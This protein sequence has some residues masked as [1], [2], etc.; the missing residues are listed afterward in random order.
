[1]SLWKVFRYEMA[2][3]PRYVRISTQNTAAAASEDAVRA[4]DPNLR[5]LVLSHRGAAAEARQT[6]GASVSLAG[7]APGTGNRERGDQGTETTPVVT[8]QDLDPETLT[9]DQGTLQVDE[10]AAMQDPLGDEVFDPPEFSASAAGE[11][12]GADGCA[13][14]RPGSCQGVEASAVVAR[15]GSERL[16]EVLAECR[17]AAESA[18]GGDPVDGSVGRFEQSSGFVE[19]A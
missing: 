12:R 15:G 1:I 17:R 10:D 3:M 2:V 19:A 14:R 9:R 6:G 18:V 11:A 8:I 7:L 16:G 4:S 5:D 13:A